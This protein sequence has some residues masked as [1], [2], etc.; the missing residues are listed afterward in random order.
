[1]NKIN[2]EKILKVWVDRILEGYPVKVFEV[3]DYV[4]DAANRVFN[5]LIGLYK[6]EKLNDDVEDALDDLMRFLATDRNLTPG[7]SIRLIS[8]LRDLVAD[9]AGLRGEERLKF[10]LMVE[11]L[12]FKAF[13]LYMACREKIFEL[14]LKEKD[15]DIEMMRKIIEYSEKIK[16]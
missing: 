5:A 14:R 7:E 13:N 8:E 3:V 2:K 6:G 10:N 12:I 11:E 15:R 1:M 4:G 9:E 16:F